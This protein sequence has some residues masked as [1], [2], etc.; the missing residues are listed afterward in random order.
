MKPMIEPLLAAADG[1]KC[2]PCACTDAG[3]LDPADPA[4]KS[5]S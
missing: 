2:E 4:R 1:M 3:L 5:G